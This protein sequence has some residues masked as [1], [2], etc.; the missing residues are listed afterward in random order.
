MKFRFECLLKA[1]P[2]FRSRVKEKFHQ[3]P[4]RSRCSKDYSKHQCVEQ[5]SEW[6]VING[7]AHVE[8]DGK[9]V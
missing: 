7:S 4:F 5:K 1:T 9:L 8:G 3:G 2:S 6:A